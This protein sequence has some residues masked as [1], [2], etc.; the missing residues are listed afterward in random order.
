M[1]KMR[2][3]EDGHVWL[4]TVI[5][6]EGGLLSK[7]SSEGRDNVGLRL[8]QLHGILLALGIVSGHSEALLTARGEELLDVRQ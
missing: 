2:I 1:R 4:P 5:R 7:T 3:N 6:E 8:D